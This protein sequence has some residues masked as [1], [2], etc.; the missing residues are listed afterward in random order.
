MTLLCRRKTLHHLC[1]YWTRIGVTEVNSLEFSW[2]LLQQSKVTSST[3][4]S[5]KRFAVD[6][7][8]AFH[9]E[10]QKEQNASRSVPFLKPLYDCLTMRGRDGKGPAH[11][12]DSLPVSSSQEHSHHWDLWRQQRISLLYASFLSFVILHTS[13]LLKLDG[14]IL[15]GARH[16][17]R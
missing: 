3:S 12:T 2:N 8:S 17:Y 5:I 10:S 11:M 16:E 4:K 9:E 13:V 14:D 1:L 7:A 15:N 6:T